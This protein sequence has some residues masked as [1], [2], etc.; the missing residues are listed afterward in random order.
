MSLTFTNQSL[1]PNVSASDYSSSPPPPNHNP[2]CNACLKVKG[3]NIGEDSSDGET[4]WSSSDEL[5]L[6]VVC[7]SVSIPPKPLFVN[8]RYQVIFQC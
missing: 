6:S 2:E 5:V 8:I 4:E 1:K 7:T 3:Y